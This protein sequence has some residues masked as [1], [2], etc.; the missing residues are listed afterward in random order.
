MQPFDR[1]QDIVTTR[2]LPQF[3]I[4]VFDG[5]NV[6]HEV[7]AQLRARAIGVGGAAVMAI[8]GMLR[9]AMMKR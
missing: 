5:W 9:N 7:L 1:A 3:A 2:R 8:I 6:L 4:A